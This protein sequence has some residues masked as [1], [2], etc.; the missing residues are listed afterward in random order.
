[1]SGRTTEAYTAVYQFIENNITSLNCKQ[2]MTDFELAMRNGLRDCYPNAARLTCWFHFC[3]AVRRRAT[4]TPHFIDLINS[5]APAMLIYR[6]IMCLPLLRSDLIIDAFE[7]LKLK[8]LAIN[9]LKFKPFLDYIDNQWMKKE[10]PE[11]ISVF[12]KTTRTNSAVEGNNSHLSSRFDKH[13]NFYKFV[14]CLRAEDYMKT[15]EME[16][17]CDGVEPRPKK[18]KIR[19]NELIYS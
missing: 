13:G 1:M 8:A 4:Q 14:T 3:Q 10:G 17:L 19:V 11:V 7:N 15:L 5:S 16:Q 18:K 9:A 2:F 12:K 6:Q